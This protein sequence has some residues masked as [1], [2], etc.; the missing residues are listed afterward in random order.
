[1]GD[2]SYLTGICGMPFAAMRNTAALIGGGVFDKFQD[3]RYGILGAGSGWFP[4]IHG[5]RRSRR[6]GAPH[7]GATPAL[8]IERVSQRAAI[9]SRLWV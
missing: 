8:K 4:C 7:D 1:M 5:A 3:L 6:D 9:L 2:N